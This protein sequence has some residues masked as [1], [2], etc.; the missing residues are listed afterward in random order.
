MLDSFHAY[1]SHFAR[2]IYLHW[3]DNYDIDAYMY[4]VMWVIFQTIL[5][6]V[7]V[8]VRIIVLV[9]SMTC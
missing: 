8:N 3:E 2:L 1:P 9:E 7:L 4:P 6:T 5:L